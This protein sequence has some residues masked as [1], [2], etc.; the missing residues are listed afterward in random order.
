MPSGELLPEAHAESLALV[1]SELLTVGTDVADRINADV[2]TALELPAMDADGTPEAVGCRLVVMI[3]EIDADV[4]GHDDSDTVSLMVA[5]TG[6][7]VSEG[8]TENDGDPVGDNVALA[9]LE[10]AKEGDSDALNVTDAHEV[11]TEDC[12]KGADGDARALRLFVARTDAAVESLRAGESDGDSDADALVHTL[13]EAATMEPVALPDG[14]RVRTGDCVKDG[15]DESLGEPVDDGDTVGDG[16]K[17]AL[18]EVRGEDVPDAD[19]HALALPQ[20]VGDSV[21]VPETLAHTVAVAGTERVDELVSD[22]EAVPDTDVVDVVDATEL[23]EIVAVGEMVAVP[24]GS[25][26]EAESDGVEETLAHT[27]EVGRSCVS[28]E[29]TLLVAHCVDEG[30]AEDDDVTLGEPDVETVAVPSAEADALRVA[31]AE[32]DGVAELLDDRLVL[33]VA[34]GELVSV[35]VETELAVVDAENVL[36]P[37]WEL[38]AVVENE[39]DV[40]REDSADPVL[41][42]L[43]VALTMAV[44]EELVDALAVILPVAQG[45]SDFAPDGVAE[46]HAFTDDDAVGVGVPDGVVLLDAVKVTHADRV[47]AADADSHDALGDA[48]AVLV[49]VVLRVSVRETVEE[50]VKDVDREGVAVL[51]LLHV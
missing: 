14:E 42:A 10:A 4:D 20:E 34:D 41:D 9:E 45:D 5:A 19:T 49:S 8:V 47:A 12:V 29:D 44:G 7:G 43:A 27:E 16:D 11:R 48:V 51:T 18:R 38:D 46:G 25:S 15:D 2:G 33:P 6:E 50:S 3:L 28:V 13:R 40:V 32:T 24:L 17:D 30:V 1:L 37:D 21:S 22:P 31:S 39:N 23:R 26:G 35:R 36:R